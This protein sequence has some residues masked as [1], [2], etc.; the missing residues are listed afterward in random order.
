MN[1]INVQFACGANPSMS[2]S[3]D[4]PNATDGASDEGGS[5][6]CCHSQTEFGTNLLAMNTSFRP[7]QALRQT[8]EN[9]SVN[10]R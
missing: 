9:V 1:I 10:T 7:M 5:S 3:S 6:Q 8:Y 2:I 4:H